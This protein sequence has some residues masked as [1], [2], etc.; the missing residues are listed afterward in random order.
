MAQKT[1]L[2][3]GLDALIP[4]SWQKPGTE[5]Q[6]S[7]DLVRKIPVENISPN[8]HQP[9]TKFDE[10]ALAELADSIREHGVISPLIVVTTSTPERYILIA[11]ERRLRASKLAGLKEVPAIIRSSTRQEQLE[12]AIIEN[13]QR[14]DLDPMER[15]N[16]YRALLDE[17]S[18]T[19]EEIAQRVGKNRATVSNSLRLLNLPASIQK[20]ISENLLSE[21][22]ARALL[23]LANA[24][25]MEHANEII[26]NL[27]LNVRQTEQLVNKLNGK[28][29][30][31]KPKTGPDA[32]AKDLENK[33]RLHFNTKVSL[34]KG[35]KG[36]NLTI[37]F[38]SDEELNNILDQ[39]NFND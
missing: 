20:A 18:L 15:A 7:G 5:T 30:P 17:F 4:G 1:G 14:E 24:R 8:P 25:S 28:A 22:H 21:G 11:G 23:G 2:G 6:D 26:Q 36:G 37:F 31:S 38:Y 10:G 12:L 13:V 27:A 16:A 29:G 3:K 32:A 19:H 34:Q 39:M 33:L 35:P 9:R